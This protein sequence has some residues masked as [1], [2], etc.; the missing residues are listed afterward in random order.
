MG[1][2]SASG[3]YAAG[4]MGVGGGGGDGQQQ[5]RSAGVNGGQTAAAAAAGAGAGGVQR[6]SRL[7]GQPGAQQE[8]GRQQGGG[9]QPPQQQ[10][11]AGVSG[12]GEVGRRVD[13]VF[14]RDTQPR[15]ADMLAEG[16]VPVGMRSGEEGSGPLPP[17]E[18]R[19]GGGQGGGNGVGELQ[20]EQ[21]QQR[22]QV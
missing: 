16:A 15:V 12:S 14:V 3:R 4:G 6:P 2:V 18:S 11:E 21:Q 9:F 5:W 19:A 8:F 22:Q 17:F 13:E 7:E 1:G 10:Q 20:Q